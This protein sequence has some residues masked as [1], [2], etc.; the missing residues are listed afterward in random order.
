M[1]VPSCA[2]QV[3]TLST[4]VTI[5]ISADKLNFVLSVSSGVIVGATVSGKV[6]HSYSRGSTITVT[7]LNTG[8]IEAQY[9]VVVGECTVN[10]QPMVAQ[11][12]CIPPK[13]SAQRRFTLIVQDSIE[14]EAKCNATLR[15]ARGDVV[16]TRAISFG[17]K[18]LKPS[19][20]SQ[21]AAPLKMDGTV[22][23]QRGSRSANSAVGSIFCVF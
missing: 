17:V 11:T 14:G 21:V 12:V 3:R 1:P 13:G 5:T 8:D 22:R 19:N 9:T 10:V 4:I 18:A 16:D 6:V 2:Y 23:R 20:G 15:N 7:V